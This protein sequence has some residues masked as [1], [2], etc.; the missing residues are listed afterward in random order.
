MQG[1]T[2]SHYRLL[3][4]LGTGG[5][6]TVYHAVDTDL[7]RP[8]AIKF[9]RPEL[10]T[11]PDLRERF[12]RE[13]R[14]A[15]ALSHPNICTIHEV[16]RAADDLYIVMQLVEGQ[17]LAERLRTGR[18]EAEPLRRIA[19]QLAEALRVAHARGI[20]HRDLKPA[21]IMLGPSRSSRT[22]PR[23]PATFLRSASPCTNLQR[24]TIRS[25]E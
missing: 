9:L 21:N 10:A 19:R 22:A 1:A 8:V 5:M 12:L 17:T 23:P 7:R 14:A 2:F 6:G 24:A 11:R 4:Q 13:A 16:G 20:V 3:G 15:A 25:G 18:I